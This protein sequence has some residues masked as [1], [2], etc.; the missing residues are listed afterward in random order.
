MSD[1]MLT[2]GQLAKRMG[3]TIRTLRYY[4]KIGLL[5]PSDY[6]EGGHRLYSLDDL[7]RLQKIQSLIFIGFSLKDIADLLEY[8]YIEEKQLSHSIAFK[9][10]ELIAEQERIRQTIDQLNHMETIISG[11]EKID[12][13]LFCFIIHSILFE[14]ENLNE[15]SQVKDSIHNFRSEER[16]ILDKEYFSLFMNLKKLVANE[17]NP[18]SDEALRFIKQLVALSN[19]SLSK[20]ETAEIKSTDQYDEPNILNPFTEEERTFLKNAFAY[21]SKL[22]E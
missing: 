9:K 14:E 18:E 3:V 11:Y 21:M 8:K 5:L 15:Y 1:D 6:T 22:Q 16:V 13:K 20:I 4:D 2:I 12:V 19:Q 17:T 7:L 10:R